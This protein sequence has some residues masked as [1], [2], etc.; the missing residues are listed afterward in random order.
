MADIII[1][2]F[3]F[4]RTGNQHVF[5][6]DRVPFIFAKSFFICFLFLLAGTIAGSSHFG[7]KRITSHH[8]VIWICILI[9]LLNNSGFKGHIHST[10]QL[11]FI[12]VV[13]SGF[14][15]ELGLYF[16]LVGVILRVERVIAATE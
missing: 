10:I 13:S 15:F 4:L 5:Q 7:R 16:E 8:F 9:H 14:I 12:L 1:V 2:F 3:Q 6:R 11:N